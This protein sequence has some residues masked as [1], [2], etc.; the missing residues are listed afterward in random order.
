MILGGRPR[1]RKLLAEPTFQI[2][3]LWGG[4]HLLDLVRT[5]LERREKSG[6]PREVVLKLNKL[7]NDYVESETGKQWTQPLG[8]GH[9]LWEVGLAALAKAAD[10]LDGDSVRDAIAAMDVDTVVGPVN[11]G[12]SPVKSVAITSLVGGQWRRSSGKYDYDLR[13]VYNAHMPSIPLDDE[14]TSLA[15][16]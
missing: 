8:Y 1:L 14:M 13:I 11:F 9:A 2:A 10:P 4:E 5:A 15:L 6:T 3:F 7:I 12:S 16:L